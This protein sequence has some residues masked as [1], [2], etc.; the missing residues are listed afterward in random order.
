VGALGNG[1][2]GNSRMVVDAVVKAAD[3]VEAEADANDDVHLFQIHDDEKVVDANDD[4]DGL[5]H[6]PGLALVAIEHSRPSI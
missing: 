2:S 3:C 4:H 1:D 5:V 6:I